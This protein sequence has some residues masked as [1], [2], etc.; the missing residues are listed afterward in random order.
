MLCEVHPLQGANLLVTSKG[1]I[2]LADFGASRKIEELA[3][4]GACLATASCLLNW[5]LRHA[6]AKWIWMWHA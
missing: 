6:T 2:K 4:C 5:Q 3:S 1:R